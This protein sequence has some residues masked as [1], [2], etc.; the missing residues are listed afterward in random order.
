M[1][2]KIL[3]GSLRV[4]SKQYRGAKYVKRFFR[5]PIRSIR[6]LRAMLTFRSFVEHLP[7][8][9]AEEYIEYIDEIES[10]KELNEKEF[11]EGGVGRT[12]GIALYM[13]VRK[14][15]PETVV[16]TGVMGGVSSTY[17]LTALEE[18]SHGKLYSID[19]P[20][21]EGKESGWLIPDG[22]KHRWELILGRSSEKLPPLLK[23]LG[24][25]N[26]FFHDS[27]HSYQNMMWEYQT[28]WPYLKQGGVLL[29]DNIDDNNAFSDF[30]KAIGVDSLI[31]GIL[32]G[33][34]KRDHSSTF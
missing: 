3:G 6:V 23:E 1:R 8:I 21:E 30:C 28:T 7:G 24:A 29:S 2:L 4:I 26:I 9:S 34:T 25:I 33:T 20:R 16:E 10:R 32:G 19:L 12:A 22:L 5:E 11:I 15:K 18:N 13:V 27:E 17:I 14:L 31:L